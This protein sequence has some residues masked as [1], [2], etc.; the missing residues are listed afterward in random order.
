MIVIIVGGVPGAGKST[1]LSGFKRIV[2]NE[3]RIRVD[4]I[5]YGSIMFEEARRRGVSNR[6]YMRRMPI[7]TQREIQRVAAERIATT[8]SSVKLIDTHFS[9]RTSYGYLPGI[10]SYVADKIS[11]THLVVVTA[12]PREIKSRRELDQGRER[13]LVSI[14]KIAEELNIELMYAVSVSNYTGAPLILVENKQGRAEEA[15]RE[16]VRRLGL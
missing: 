7:Q 4:V 16:M 6:D 3:K 5:N 8:R 2:E 11:P 13:D 14:N 1:V 9:I 12:P 10:P 15:S